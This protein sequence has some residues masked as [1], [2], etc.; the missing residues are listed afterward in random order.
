VTVRA[1]NAALSVLLVLLYA[2]PVA[3]VGSVVLP[4]WREFPTLTLSYLAVAA[5]GSVQVASAIRGL[6]G[7]SKRKGGA[8][9]PKL[10]PCFVLIPLALGAS[11][12]QVM[13]VAMTV[14]L[15]GTLI[16]VIGS[17]LFES[18]PVIVLAFTAYF[19]VTDLYWRV[20]MGE[21]FS[22]STLVVAPIFATI[23]YLCLKWVWCGVS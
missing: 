20:M 23:V 17:V 1:K 10:L 9:F 12:G 14:L 13:R 11:D 16:L 3:M 18:I 21:A 2:L 15:Q 19:C 8:S 7:G 6:A 4:R 5:A 22:V